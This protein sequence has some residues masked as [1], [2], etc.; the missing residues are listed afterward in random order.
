MKKGRIVSLT[1]RQA[2]QAIRRGESR[3]DWHAAAQM[4]DDE[5]EAHV[6]AEPEDEGAEVDWSGATIHIPRPKESVTMRIDHDV[7]AFFRKDG[8]GYQTRMNAILRSYVDH[9]SRRGGKR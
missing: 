3:S 8:P 5:I 1:Q 4:S 9:A 7:L 6:A 2:K